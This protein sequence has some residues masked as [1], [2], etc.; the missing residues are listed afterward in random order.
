MVGERIAHYEVTEKLGE[1]GMGVVYKA[2]D[3][4]LDRFVALKLLRADRTASQN[5]NSRFVQEA[6]SASALNHPNIIHIYDIVR[7]GDGQ[8]I[9][10]EFI[11]G[12]TL[13]HLIPHNG[14]PLKQALH[15]AVQMADALASAHAAGIVHRDLKPANVMVTDEGSVRIL[16]FGLAK[17]TEAEQADAFA[18][19]EVEQA[20]L[21]EEGTILGTV[22]YM[23]PEQAE[24]KRLDYRSDIFSFGAV[25]YE[26]VT[27]RRPFVGESKISVLSA[28]LKQ[29]PDPIAE[30]PDAVTY[31]VERIIQRCLKKDLQRRWQSTKDLKVALE[32]AREQLASGAQSGISVVPSRLR[33]TRFVSR[34]RWLATPLLMLLAALATYFPLRSHHAAPPEFQR[35]TF[36]R[37]DVTG[38][39]FAP[40][41]T[42]VYSAEWGGAP[43]SIFSMRPGS[44]ENRTL[45]L[46]PA[47][48]ASVSVNGELAILI[49]ASSVG[50][51]GTLARV[52]LEGDVP[53][54][55]LENVVH[56]D[57]SPDGKQLAVVR[58]LGR[59]HRLEYPIGKILC[60]NTSRP[61]HWIRI[62]P[63]GL[64]IAF[65]E[66][67]P[68]IGDYAI[69]TVDLN[70]EKRILTR[71]WRGT[72]QLAWTR[73][74]K[75]VWFSASTTVSD[76]SLYAV[77]MSGELRRVVQI[78]GWII[79]E[80]IAPDGRAL[81]GVTTSRI[82]M[83]CLPP[84]ATAE[85][86]L[87]WLDTSLASGLSS[88]GKT[89]L[90]NEL[91]SGEGRN[92]AI[93]V[94]GTDGS[95]AKLLGH[96]NLPV[97]SPDGKWVLCVSRETQGNRLMLL[98]SGPGET[99][100]L[101]SNVVRSDAAEF[102]PDGR[103][104]LFTGSEPER[105][106]RTYVL[107]LSGGKPRPV[108]PEGVKASGLSPDGRFAVSTHDGKVS[109]VPVAGGVPRPSARILPTESVAGW[110]QDGRCL[111]LRSPD[112]K[113]TTTR[114]YLLDVS[115]GK[116]E[117]Y[118][119][120][121]APEPG[122]Q[123]LQPLAITPNGKS[124]AYSFQRDLCNL[125]LVAGLK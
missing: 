49:G 1:G 14:L 54:E 106:P 71:G 52:P 28:I 47:R 68:Q 66:F 21:T 120:I 27:G 25:L 99:R 31:E 43:C 70:G 57:W 100:I 53:R 114:V 105:P 77:T 38:A 13:D 16:D 112:S 10:M 91:S 63:S 96:G 94:R 69:A 65:F 60:K 23:S 18:Q 9:V 42:V 30:Q 55:I 110:H 50:T 41:G 19:T 111:Y 61:P 116:R 76:P 74:E 89:I 39:R 113:G 101:S 67:D 98:P 108:T 84:G 6:K 97:L 33:M 86:D 40:G 36:R 15:Y 2:R 5:G 78:P 103:R 35:L 7:S 85:R 79:V 8:A 124:Y 83:M 3:T 81:F 104:I 4:H 29:E 44:R 37:G 102:F 32:E 117:L 123:L 93:Y 11:P 121:R 45:P 90:F 119:E 62:S 95:P 58:T 80:D 109:L 17:L 22:A 75:E 115:T 72:A 34:R 92:A 73:N 88:D 12:R 87:S 125:Y 107:D 122:S 48:L 26:M 56:A 59:E 20:G 46:P 82:G 64:K 24:G 51:A 118:R